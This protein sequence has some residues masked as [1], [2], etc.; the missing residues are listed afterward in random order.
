MPTAKTSFITTVPSIPMSAKTEPLRIDSLNVLDGVQDPPSS[1]FS[2][3]Q[4]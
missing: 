2:E 3:E 1:H 4:T